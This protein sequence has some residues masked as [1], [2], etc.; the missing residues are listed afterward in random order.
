MSCDL[1]VQVLL[2]RCLLAGLAEFGR[3]FVGQFKTIRISCL[4]VNT[5]LQT[6][7]WYPPKTPV[8]SLWDA[9]GFGYHIAVNSLSLLPPVNDMGPFIRVNHRERDGYFL[10]FYYAG[11]CDTNTKF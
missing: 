9:T 4:L 8:M 3:M 7:D 11:R 5:V 2:L 6:V 1:D 10:D